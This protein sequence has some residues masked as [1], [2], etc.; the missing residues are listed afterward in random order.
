MES[1]QPEIVE[2]ATPTP[3]T[4][5]PVKTQAPITDVGTFWQRLDEVLQLVKSGG[6]ANNKLESIL[7]TFEETAQINQTPYRSFIFQ[8]ERMS[9]TSNDDVIPNNEVVVEVVTKNGGHQ[10]AETFSQF[11]IRFEKSLVNVKS[12][13]LLSAVIPN[14]IQNIPDNQLIYHDLPH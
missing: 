14:A 13:Q 6:T 1:I 12:I 11:R 5:E 4:E 9:I 10:P 2:E 8:P 3:V 7:E